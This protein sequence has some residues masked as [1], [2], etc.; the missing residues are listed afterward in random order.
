MLESAFQYAQE[1]GSDTA[2]YE[3]SGMGKEIL[4]RGPSLNDCL[5]DLDPT[6]VIQD[7]A[8][9]FLGN[10]FVVSG[11]LLPSTLQWFVD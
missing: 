10:R 7:L 8:A 3:D 4:W 9:M 6:Q 2:G 1:V 11:Q 5:G